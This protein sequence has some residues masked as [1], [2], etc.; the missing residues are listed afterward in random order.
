M[1]EAK[2]FTLIEVLVVLSILALVAIL[3]YNFFG[4]TMKDATA[5]QQAVKIYNDFRTIGDA[6]D[7]YIMKYGKSPYFDLDIDPLGENAIDGTPYNFR[8]LGG[9]VKATPRPDSDITAQTFYTW[10][11]GCDD[12]YGDGDIDSCIELYAIPKETC[13]LYNLMFTSLGADIVDTEAGGYPASG[14]TWCVQRTTGDEGSYQVFW[15][16]ENK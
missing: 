13:R 4:S 14:S 12:F 2:A 8:D 7:M 3:S 10:S 6:Y 1:R 9:F 15:I 16:F 5:K 11:D